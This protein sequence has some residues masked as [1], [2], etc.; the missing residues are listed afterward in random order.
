MKH[1][2]ATL[3]IISLMICFCLLL[4]ACLPSNSPAEADNSA[5]DSEAVLKADYAGEELL[6][7]GKYQEYIAEDSEYTVKI[8]FNAEEVLS[9]VQFF[10]LGY[11]EDGNYQLA[12]ILYTIEEIT[13]DLP[14]V[15]GVVFY[16]DMTAYGISFNDIAGQ[17]HNFAVSISGKDGALILNECDIV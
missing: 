12:E 10:S 3:K 13:P 14:F 6:N 5:H 15:A 11:D 8:A 9:D 17:R 2:K 7:G 1:I 4:T 16:G